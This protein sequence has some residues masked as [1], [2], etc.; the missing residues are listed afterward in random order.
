MRK[1]FITPKP[2][3][4]RNGMCGLEGHDCRARMQARQGRV[5]SNRTAEHQQQNINETKEYHRHTSKQDIRISVRLY[6]SHKY[7]A[8]AHRQGERQQLDPL[9][10]GGP[11]CRW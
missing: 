9:S 4:W 3:L 5:G 10:G 6:R 7:H 11:S 2:I 8:R 1:Y